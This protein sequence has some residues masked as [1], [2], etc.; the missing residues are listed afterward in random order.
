MYN[1]H[2]KICVCGRGHKIFLVLSDEDPG[3]VVRFSAPLWPAALPFVSL[4]V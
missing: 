1:Q 4:I 3:V 2:V